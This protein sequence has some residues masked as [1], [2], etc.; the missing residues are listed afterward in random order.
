MWALTRK[1]I[2]CSGNMRHKPSNF[3]PIR[4]VSAHCRIKCPKLNSASPLAIFTAASFCGSAEWFY[5]IATRT[6]RNPIGEKMGGHWNS[7][8]SYHHG[9]CGTS[10]VTRPRRG[11]SKTTQGVSS[12]I[13]A[14]PVKTDLGNMGAGP[15]LGA[16]TN[17]M[18]KTAFFFLGSGIWMNRSWQGSTTY[19]CDTFSPLRQASWTM[20]VTGVIQPMRLSIV[21]PYHPISSHIYRWAH[22]PLGFTPI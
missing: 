22:I 13:A 9:A 3:N 15:E 12:L 17:G 21:V 4:F 8:K 10:F 20:G 5:S 18:I 16:L 1:V 7:R 11:P 6:T 14:S 2:A 19:I